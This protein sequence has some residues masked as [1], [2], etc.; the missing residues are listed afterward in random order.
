MNLAEIFYAK[1]GGGFPGR[2]DRIFYARGYVK[3]LT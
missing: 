1:A 3:V 2:R